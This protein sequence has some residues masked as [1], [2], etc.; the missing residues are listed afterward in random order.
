MKHSLRNFVVLVLIGFYDNAY[1]QLGLNYSFHT[2]SAQ[3]QSISGIPDAIE[4]LD[5][6]HSNFYINPCNNCAGYWLDA[7]LEV[8][9]NNAF[10]PYNFN[11]SF[12]GLEIPYLKIHPLEGAIEFFGGGFIKCG[13]LHSPY[14]TVYQTGN[15]GTCINNSNLS[16]AG[17]EIGTFATGLWGHNIVQVTGFSDF[18]PQTESFNDVCFSDLS[19]SGCQST[20]CQVRYHTGRCYYA[21]QGNSPN[22][23]MTFEWK[24]FHSNESVNAYIGEGSRKNFQIILYENSNTISVHF[25]SESS[26]GLTGIFNQNDE[27]DSNFAILN[28]EG[29]TENN[30]TP[31]AISQGTGYGYAG[32]TNLVL[33]WIAQI[34][35]DIDNDGISV[36]EGDCNDTNALVNP[37]APEICDNIDNNCNVQIDEGFDLDV[38]GVSVCAG[39]CNDLDSTVYTGA[40]DITDG[41]DNNCDG[42][43]DENYDSD[44]DGVTPA[45]GDCDDSSA[46]IGPNQIEICNGIDD[47]CNTT[48]DEGFDQDQDGFTT[49]SGDCDDGN[50]LINP[51]VTDIADGIDNDC[52]GFFDENADGDGDGVSPADGD[53]NDT[54]PAIGPDQIEFCNGIDD[55]CNLL[56]DENFD[57]DGDGFT[58]CNGDCNDLNVLVNPSAT[59]I[60]DNVDNNCDGIV[61][62]TVDSDGDGFTPADG[63]CNDSNPSVFPG[64]TEV[65]NNQ[66]DNCNTLVDENL[67]CDT[68]PSNLVIPTGFSPNNDGY[69]DT[70][71]I[72]ALNALSNYSVTVLN[73]WGQE[74]FSTQNI[75]TGWDGTFQ[76]QK[77]PVGDYFFV[78]TLSDGTVYNGA[79][80]IKY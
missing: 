75:S 36:S 32:S 66:D 33:T 19:T 10:S 30:P 27:C 3:Y 71:Q 5:T 25:G 65:C 51:S 42:I 49:C 23:K 2:D 76:G 44:G 16:E 64:Q 38:D 6:T 7:G 12:N 35:S 43:I 53:C 18:N 45:D 73:R 46:Q 1:S 37:T 56:I 63:D 26:V 72:P 41:V 61:D 11:F 4:I 9:V 34:D 14:I 69:N 57:A 62:E 8:L 29:Q 80:T 68:A 55:N 13:N 15:S 79:L 24:N 40:F 77:L 52:D 59:E 78:I 48:V 67:D 70:W 20:N 54:N 74:L 22:R 39:D 47:N 17:I 21:I 60:D 28:S 58:L 31:C 50:S